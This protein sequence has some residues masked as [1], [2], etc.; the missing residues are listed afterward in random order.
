MAKVYNS[1]SLIDPNMYSVMNQQIQNRVANQLN[2]DKM[3]GESVRHML[4]GIG[5]AVDDA[6]TNWKN[7]KEEQARYDQIMGQSTI[8]QQ[9]DPNYI[10]AV[11]DYAK[12]GNSQPITSYMLGKEAAEARKESAQHS[13]ATQDWHNRLEK[14]AAEDKYDKLRK[15]ALAAQDAGNYTEAEYLS[16]QAKRL[17]TAWAERGHDIGDDFDSILEAAKKAKEE[18]AA[19]RA[20]EKADQEA[21]ELG[22][23]NLKAIQEV[24]ENERLHKVALFKN[25]LPT[26]F[27]KEADKQAVYD[28]IEQN[29]DMTIPEKTALHEE[30]RKI[31]SGSTQKKRSIQSATAGKAGEATGKAIDEKNEKKKLADAG[32]KAI[33]EGR[34]PTRAQQ[35]AIDEGN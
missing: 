15:E 22:E 6:Y 35:K 19:K 3:L 10:A 5:G 2:R 14:A 18:A 28:L 1:R 25:S 4:T 32:R 12:T 11:K 8:A 7:K 17:K 9:S 24:N 29:E 33:K 23:K 27:A 34:V 30:I 20:Q 16:N 31:E 13:N 21:M 26:T